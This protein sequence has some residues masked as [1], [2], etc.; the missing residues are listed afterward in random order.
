MFRYQQISPPQEAV[1]LPNN[2]VSAYHAIT[3]DLGLPLPWPR[4]SS[5]HPAHANDP[6]LVWGSSSSVGQFALRI[7]RHW[8]YENILATASNQHHEM[9]KSFGARQ[10]F[11]YRDSN[12]TSQILESAN[13][14]VSFVLD[15]IGSKYG[16]VAHIAKIAKKG[17]KVAIMLPVII[18]DPSETEAPEYSMDVASSAD[19]AEGIN[20][21][22]FRTDPF[23]RRDNAYP[24]SFTVLE[25]LLKGSSPVRDYADITC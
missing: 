6:I 4:P 20:A 5:L 2:F 8:G 13:G 22:G 23:S 24:P 7:L 15:C 14:E 25:H 21:R 10:V 17:N 16:S 19:W 3:T 9:L 18:K 12:V 1:T 11:D